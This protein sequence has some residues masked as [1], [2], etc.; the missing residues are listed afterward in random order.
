MAIHLESL[1]RYPVKGLSVEDLASV[2]LTAGEGLPDDRRFALAHGADR[3]ERGR[4]GWQPKRHFLNLMRNERLAALQTAYDSASGVLT[5][6]RKGRQVARG[7]I[8]QQIGRDLIDQF[9]AAYMRDE[10]IRSPRLVESEGVMFTDVQEKFLSIINLG[11]VRDIER[12]TRQPVDPIRFRG[13]LMI[14]GAR[15]WQEFDWID[16]EITVGEAKLAVVESI[17][18]CAATNVDPATGER[19]LNIPKSLMS[20]FGHGNCGIFARVISGGSITPGDSFTV[21]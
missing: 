16:R 11:S 19:D 3:Y 5:I 13:N 1:C 18:R 14:D 17:G 7:N 2:T 9:F 4:S 12:V 8:T 15:P 20:G 10:S 21:L 6:R